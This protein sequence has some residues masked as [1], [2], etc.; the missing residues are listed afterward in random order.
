[1]SSNSLVLTAINGEPRVHDLALA[2]RLGFD[3]PRDIRKIIK[4]NED[5]LLKFGGC[6][7]V[8]RVVEGN[9]TAEFYLNQKQ[10]IF[11]CMKSETERA[12]DVQIEIV[13]VFDAYLNGE[14]NADAVPPLPP[15]REPITPAHYLQLQ[16]LVRHISAHCH[17]H[18]KAQGAAWGRLRKDYDADSVLRLPVESFDSARALLADILIQARVYFKD[19]MRRD[20]IFINEVIR[21]GARLQLVL[22]MLPAAR[23]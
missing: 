9:E 5:K 16:E 14:L 22:P 4:R 17:Q 13:H 2:E 3:R 23:D 10:A 19:R 7:T 8:A 12:F 20:D 6:A 21:R 1:M 15:I 18:G 11:I